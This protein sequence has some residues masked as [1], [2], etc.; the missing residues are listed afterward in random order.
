MVAHKCCFNDKKPERRRKRER[1]FLMMLC[2]F[3]VRFR[4]CIFTIGLCTGI[5]QY[6]GWHRGQYYRAMFRWKRAYTLHIRYGKCCRSCD[7]SESCYLRATFSIGARIYSI[8]NL[9][10]NRTIQ[11]ER[12]IFCWCVAAAFFLLIFFFL[13][14]NTTKMI[15]LI[16]H[17]SQ[18]HLPQPQTEFSSVEMMFMINPQMKFELNGIDLI[19]PQ[20]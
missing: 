3:L 6:V 20:I 1:D 19:W 5:W 14:L 15:L 18:K 12:I 13:L 4:C 7:W 2:I 16:I 9:H 17:I 10:R 8:S 11:V